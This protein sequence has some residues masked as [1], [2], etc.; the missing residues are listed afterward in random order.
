LIAFIDDDECPD[1][2]WLVNLFKAHN[3]FNVDGIL[4][5][6]LP[7]YETT[8]PAWIIKGKFYERP[9]HTTGT[10][11][12]WS[13]TRT[14]NV[15]IRRGVFVD[16]DNMFRPE[17]GSGGEDRDFF[18]RMIGQGFQFVWC[19]EAP[20]FESVPPDRYK[21]CFLLRRAL[22]RGAKLPYNNSTIPYLKS[23]IAIPLY[24]LILPFLLFIQHHIFMRYLIKVFDHIGRVLALCGIQ[25][26][27]EKYVMK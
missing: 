26:I 15:L 2:Y 24:M 12:H 5:P 16:D 14:G 8:P 17:Y 18:K 23:L 1:Q 22:L 3:E 25:V 13:D 6:V 7:H 27:R 9:S 20:V 4:G 11:L 19:A 10:V 21:R